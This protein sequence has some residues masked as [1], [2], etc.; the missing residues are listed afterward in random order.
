MVVQKR[1]LTRPYLQCADGGP[2]CVLLLVLLRHLAGKEGRLPQVPE[3]AVDA[4]ALNAR[5]QPVAR[6][7]QVLAELGRGAQDLGHVP[8]TN[9]AVRDL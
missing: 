3:L 2:P 6:V 8:A 4:R 1:L 5:D 7:A 9:K